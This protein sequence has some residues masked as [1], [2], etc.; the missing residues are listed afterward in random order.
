M[1]GIFLGR[2]DHIFWNM[3]CCL[4]VC[5]LQ[6][7]SGEWSAAPPCWWS[8]PQAVRVVQCVGDPKA[9]LTIVS[10][11]CLGH[12]HFGIFG[13]GQCRLSMDGSS[14]K[15]A[16]HLGTFG[17]WG[18]PWATANGPLWVQSPASG[19]GS[20]PNFSLEIPV[21][22]VS[23]SSYLINLSNIFLAYVLSNLTTVPKRLLLI[24]FRCW[25]FYPKPKMEN[26]RREL[27]VFISLSF[28]IPGI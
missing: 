15:P 13:P 23:I 8:I 21:Q 27:K 28:L 22:L 7:V 6:G 11:G 14:K 4:V 1:L 18:T 9:R 17:A 10:W 20:C 25:K 12:P 5:C 26:P 3:V 24:Y 2:T 16:I 19:Y